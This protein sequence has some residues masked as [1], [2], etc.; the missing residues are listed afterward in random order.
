MDTGKL[1]LSMPEIKNGQIFTFLRY[2]HR[3]VP[4]ALYS[5]GPLHSVIWWN[6]L[7]NGVLRKEKEK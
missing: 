2:A 4:M 6:Y 1:Q 7:H 5:L 3:Y